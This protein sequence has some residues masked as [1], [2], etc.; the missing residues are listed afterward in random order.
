[1]VLILSQQ[2]LL[3]LHFL[4]SFQKIRHACLFTCRLSFMLCV[5]IWGTF[6]R[7][8]NFWL[9]LLASILFANADISH[10]SLEH[11]V[12][13]S[14]HENATYQYTMIS[15][16]R[17]IHEELIASTYLVRLHLIPVVSLCLTRTF[18]IS[19]SAL[20]WKKSIC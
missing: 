3:P 20:E 2:T 6:V 8:I 5:C 7:Q 16:M 17:S 18:Q 12:F 9:G 13:P 19:A 11:F 15:L 14:W 1:M 10:H 4:R